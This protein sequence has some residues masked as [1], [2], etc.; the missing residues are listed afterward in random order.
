[1]II[2]LLLNGSWSGSQLTFP[3]MKKKDKLFLLLLF[4]QGLFGNLE[5]FL[6]LKGKLS[7][8][9]IFHLTLIGY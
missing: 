2:F 3:Q 1:M 8:S 4:Y 6:S 9:L 7:I 5:M